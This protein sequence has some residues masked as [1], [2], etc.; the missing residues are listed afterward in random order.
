MICCCL[1][2]GGVLACGLADE[3]QLQESAA[4]DSEQLLRSQDLD[5]S[6][7]AAVAASAVV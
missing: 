6:S 4:I 2:S 5:G 7:H 1:R 3:R